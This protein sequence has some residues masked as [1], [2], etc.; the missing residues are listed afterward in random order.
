MVSGLAGRQ[1]PDA[2]PR[3]PAAP[4]AP[5]RPR[6]FAGGYGLLAAML[7]VMAAPPAGAQDA[8]LTASV[9]RETIHENESFTY[10]LR[11]E[12]RVAGE[13][14]VSAVERDFDVLN[15]SRSTRIQMLNGRTE[16]VTEWVFQLM[17]RAA[18]RFDL[19]AVE[20]ADLLSNPVSVE[21]L[22]AE[23]RGDAPADIFMEVE[24]D[25]A[26]AYV[27]AQ[28]I[29]TVRLFIGVSTGRA[30][31]TA[32]LVTGGEA[33]VER[34]GED[35]QFQTV[36]GQRNFIVRERRYA[37]FPQQS[38]PLTL[39]PATFEA[40]VI[41][42]RGFS[43][44]QRL[45]SDT[46][47][48]AVKPAVAPPASHPNAV[49]LPAIDLELSER[50]ADQAQAFSLGVP[51][52]RVLRI[53]ATGL[54][55]TQLPELEL[56]QADGI[57]QYP[58]QPELERQVTDR[59]IEATRIERYAVIAQAPGEVTL[60]AAELPWWNV[61]EER[62]EVA[63]IEPSV[64]PVLPG[65][66]EPPSEAVPPAPAPA[67][68]P[69]IERDAG[70]WPWIAGALALGWLLTALGWLRSARGLAGH[71]PRTEPAVAKAPSGRRLFKQL[72]AACAVND[73]PRAQ[74]L[75][76]DWARLQFPQSP[77]TS[78]GALAE[79]VG[80]A[81]G[82]EIGR[83][84][85]H[86]YGPAGRPWDGARLSALLGEINAVTRARKSD[87]DDPLLPLYR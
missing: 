5:P 52:T 58:D 36:R 67:A 83:L 49:W 77:P 48:L 21:V 65:T 40:M 60:P 42:T 82:E 62:W 8:S 35:R 19:P 87:T 69:V 39:G 3:V 84:E 10:V 2:P 73:A 47:E 4:A 79:R 12:G 18:G 23:D 44:V 72:R 25:P 46:I 6:L 30:T 7:L 85:A 31:L 17:P 32:P 37:V 53:E 78:L 75:L 28:V 20:L 16:Q 22:P 61:V 66:E 76:L 68:A 43:R 1:R 70:A 63:R 74:Q 41:P 55:E 9:D 13:P 29:Y 71:R 11:A 86:L 14:D 51:R 34:L 57:R 64:L 26:T 81:L 27:Q 54:L 38:G 24:V 50:W 56:G 59:G 80:G 45:R 33:I 15:Q